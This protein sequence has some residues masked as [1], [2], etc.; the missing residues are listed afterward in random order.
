MP[1]GQWLLRAGRAR[2][3]R[4]LLGCVSAAEA[5]SSAKDSVEMFWAGWWDPSVHPVFCWMS[6]ECSDCAAASR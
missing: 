5:G 1:A 2:G 3:T 4:G 6:A